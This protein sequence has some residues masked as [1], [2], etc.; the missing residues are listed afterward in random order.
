MIRL[1]P[2]GLDILGL[3]VVGPP[4]LLKS[5][6]GQLRA[7]LTAIYRALDKLAQLHDSQTGEKLVAVLDPRTKK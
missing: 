4:D 6:E 7:A 1:L 3:F 5:R 2:G